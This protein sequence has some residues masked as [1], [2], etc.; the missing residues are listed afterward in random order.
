[1]GGK[2]LPIQA[3]TLTAD[4]KPGVNIFCVAISPG[5]NHIAARP[6]EAGLAAG[7]SCPRALR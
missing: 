1:V 3:R 5:K 2:P 4:E 6:I 7:I